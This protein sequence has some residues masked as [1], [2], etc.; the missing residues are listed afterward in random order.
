MSMGMG[1]LRDRAATYQRPLAGLP[2]VVSSPTNMHTVI[3]EYAGGSD[4]ES[5]PVSCAATPVAASVDG[6][7]WTYGHDWCRFALITAS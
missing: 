1:S 7:K 4:V 3:Y 2:P 5:P 6:D